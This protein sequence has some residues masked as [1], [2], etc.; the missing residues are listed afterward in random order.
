MHGLFFVDG[1][2]ESEDFLLLAR[3]TLV[4]DEPMSRAELKEAFDIHDPE[5][6]NYLQPEEL[7]VILRKA[8]L[9]EDKID[10]LVVEADTD[11]DGTIDFEGEWNYACS[12]RIDIL[13]I[14]CKC[15]F[16]HL[17]TYM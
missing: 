15:T 4:P 6:N 3:S 16:L 12:A 5:G 2:I 13:R 17:I 9:E 10:I 11:G 14:P 7:K 1:I 8:N